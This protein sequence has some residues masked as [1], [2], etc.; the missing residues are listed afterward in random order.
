MPTVN[1]WLIYAALGPLEES[2]AS[3]GRPHVDPDNAVALRA[4]FGVWVVPPFSRW[5]PF[6]KEQ[7]RLSLAYYLRRPEVLSGEVLGS[8]QDLRNED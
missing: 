8:L 1:Y 7:L 6:W 3:G 4:E 5:A 2:G